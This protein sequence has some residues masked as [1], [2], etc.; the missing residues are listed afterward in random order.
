MI[1]VR[2]IEGSLK[3]LR[4]TQNLVNICYTCTFRT[5]KDRVINQLDEGVKITG[6]IFFTVITEHFIG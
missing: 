5:N 6:N 3:F 4:I 2:S 1:S